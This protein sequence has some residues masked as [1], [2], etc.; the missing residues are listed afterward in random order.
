MGDELPVGVI[1]AVTAVICL[2]LIAYAWR[3]APDAAARA[4]SAAE[5]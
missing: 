1:V 3:R 2:A 5:E 4:A